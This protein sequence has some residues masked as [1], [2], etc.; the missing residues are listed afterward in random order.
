MS[1]I[2]SYVVTFSKYY[3]KFFGRNKPDNVQEIGALFFSYVPFDTV[4]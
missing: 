3:L 4:Q 1:N 2:S